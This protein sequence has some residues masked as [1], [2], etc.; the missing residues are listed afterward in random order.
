MSSNENPFDRLERERL[1]TTP[2]EQARLDRLLGYG[3]PETPEEQVQRFKDSFGL[4]YEGAIED[5]RQRLA[6]QASDPIAKQ[7]ALGLNEAELVESIQARLDRLLDCGDGEPNDHTGR[8]RRVSLGS[9][10]WTDTNGDRYVN[11]RGRARLIE[12]GP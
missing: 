11:V 3:P 8:R 4:M 2:E 7:T 1:E 9:E 10:Y 5:E 6:N 12:P